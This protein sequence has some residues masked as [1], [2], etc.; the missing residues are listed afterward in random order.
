MNSG[1]LT[2]FLLCVEALYIQVHALRARP[3]GHYVYLRGVYRAE[4]YT[5]AITLHLAAVSRLR[6]SPGTARDRHLC[7]TLVALF[8][9]VELS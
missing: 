4:S 5:Q 7:R 6:P 9:A 8:P 3:T 1:E 2:P